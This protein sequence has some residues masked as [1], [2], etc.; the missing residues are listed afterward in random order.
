[1]PYPGLPVSTQPQAP[2]RHEGMILASALQPVPARLVRRIRAGEF[3][4]MRDL[5]SD[6]VALHDQ[7]EAIQ[8]PLVNAVTPGTLRPRVRE[9]P[10][11]IS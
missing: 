4:E 10:S 3:V 6:N 8:G 1:M 2:S 9:V 11:L 7:L 5:L